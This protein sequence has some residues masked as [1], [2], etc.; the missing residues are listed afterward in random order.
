[1]ANFSKRELAGVAMIFTGSLAVLLFVSSLVISW[2]WLRKSY[3]GSPDFAG[4]LKWLIDP[5]NKEGMEPILTFTGLILPPALALASALFAWLRASAKP[6]L[7]T[8][9][10]SVAKPIEWSRIRGDL[11]KTVRSHWIDDYLRHSIFQRIRLK[12]GIEKVPEAIEHPFHIERLSGR[13]AEL[14]TS[15]SLLTLFDTSG[16]SL[17]IL[18]E[19]GSGKTITLVQLAGLLLDRAAQ[20]SAAPVPVVVPLISWAVNR[21]PLEKW[22]RSELARH[23]GLSTRNTLELLAEGKRLTLLLD[24]LD[25]V[26]AE[27]RV[28]CLAAINDF[29]S[30]FAADLVVCCRLAEYEELP[31]KLRL[32]DALRILPLNTGQIDAYFG[33]FGERL[34]SLRRSVREQ[35]E[36]RELAAT[37]LMLNILA[38]L[39]S[40]DERL[41]KV[42]LSASRDVWRDAIFARYVRMMF[43]RKEHSMADGRPVLDEAPFT[44]AQAVHWLQQIARRMAEHNVATLFLERLHPRW[45]TTWPVLTLSLWGLCIVFAGLRYGLR[46]G[47]SDGVVAGVAAGVNVIVIAALINS[48]L[49]NKD[50]G[51]VESIHFRWNPRGLASGLV[52]GFGTWMTYAMTYLLINVFI[53]GQ[54]RG[55]VIALLGVA[56]LGMVFGG[57]LGLLGGFTELQSYPQPSRPNQGI[58]NSMRMSLVGGLVMAFLM[59]FFGFAIDLVA[60]PTIGGL[61]C[62]FFVLGGGAVV[63]HYATRLAL[64]MEGTLPFPLSDRKLIGFLDAMHDRI[65]LTRVGGGWVFIHGLLLEFLAGE[66]FGTNALNV[67]KKLQAERGPGEKAKRH[68]TASL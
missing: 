63:L 21:K 27:A 23:Y 68:S 33:A 1:M 17:L 31:E 14:I 26:R 59:A 51:L 40:S 19:P 53:L 24:G 61:V 34:D 39:Y 65:L 11:I 5:Q 42:S 8:G 20:N 3:D 29:K 7:E 10:T 9:P 56:P 18:G 45:V 16:G 44:E 32:T 52:V 55:F 58:R 15:A 12:L 62:G 57:I 49:Y 36:L 38:T 48:T 4:V 30:A 13:K 37:P 50:V 47:V 22:L 54:L 67:A 64:A 28:E 43:Q 41:A 60:A 2:L 66:P 46:Y 25:E 6:Q 35:P